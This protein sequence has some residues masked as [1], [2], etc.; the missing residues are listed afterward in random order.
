MALGVLQR[1]PHIP[2]ILLRGTI[3]GLE[4][5]EPT[6]PHQLQLCALHASPLWV[7][8]GQRCTSRSMCAVCRA[9]IAA[10]VIMKDCASFKRI[11]TMA[12]IKWA[13]RRKPCGSASLRFIL[14]AASSRCRIRCDVGIQLTNHFSFQ[15]SCSALFLD[16]SAFL[17]FKG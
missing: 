17:L 6:R 4:S 13:K 11:G 8:V 5:D 16:H 12:T 7:L 3:L 15:P 1:N 2:H 14:E 10:I 9:V